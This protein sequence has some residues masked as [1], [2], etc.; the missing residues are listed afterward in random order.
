MATLNND[1]DKGDT[2]KNNAELG[3][4]RGNTELGNENHGNVEGESDETILCGKGEAM[5]QH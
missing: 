5:L 3:L 4:Q 2:M 1:K